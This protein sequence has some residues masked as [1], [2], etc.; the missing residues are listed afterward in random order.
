[1]RITG[2]VVC[3]ASFSVRGRHGVIVGVGMLNAKR[4]E[5]GAW[6]LYDEQACGSVPRPELKGALGFFSGGK[7]AQR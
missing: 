6:I 5:D 3:L 7:H 1:M 4:R 2:G